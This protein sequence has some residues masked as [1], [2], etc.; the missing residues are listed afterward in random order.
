MKARN[1][2]SGTSLP[3]PAGWKP[4]PLGGWLA[5]TVS[6][7]AALILVVPAVLLALDGDRVQ[8]AVTGGVAVL[9]VVTA[10]LVRPRRRRA[11]ARA[12]LVEV[13]GTHTPGL[14]FPV[15][16]TPPL[17]SVGL[18]LAGLVFV[19]LALAAG[20]AAVLQGEWPMLAGVAVLVAVGA[21]FL[22]GGIAGLRSARTG[23]GVDLTPRHVVVGLGIDR[24]VLAW[25]EIAAI[26]ATTVRYGFRTA[27]PAPVQHW[28]LIEARDPGAVT[29]R[30]R[31][32]PAALGRLAGRVSAAVVAAVPTGRLAG[33]PVVCFRTLEHYASRPDARAELGDG[34]AAAA[35]ARQDAA[36]A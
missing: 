16:P 4:L 7:A 26:G 24:V 3:P 25:D 13:E 32:R 35:I 12:V 9:L 33:D 22:L 19:A 28:L 14:R 17:V 10:V 31:P 27:I 2:S 21:V 30:S 1:G 29:E 36:N 15:R 20:V 6:A 8:T 5:T 11:P 23:L 18:L 34:T